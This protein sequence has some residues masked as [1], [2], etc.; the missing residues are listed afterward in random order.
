MKS[1]CRDEEP[2]HPSVCIWT[3]EQVTKAL[4]LKSSHAH[5]KLINRLNEVMQEC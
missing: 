2:V 4:T 3:F 1:G 5:G